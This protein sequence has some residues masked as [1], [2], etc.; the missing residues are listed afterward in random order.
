MR[1]RILIDLAPETT[2]IAGFPPTFDSSSARQFGLT[3]VWFKRRLAATL[4]PA[5]FGQE[6]SPC[7]PVTLGVIPLT[8]Y[9]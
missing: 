5:K 2:P 9:V 3:I 7:L 8:Q 4:L 1:K 6:L